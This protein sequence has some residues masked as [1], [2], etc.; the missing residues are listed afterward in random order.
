MLSD[1][2]IGTSSAPTYLPAHFFKT[3]DSGGNEREF[4]LVDGGVAAN[5][6]VREPNLAPDSFYLLNYELMILHLNSYSDMCGNDFAITYWNPGIAGYEANRDSVP[7]KSRCSGCTTKPRLQEIPS[8]VSRDWNF[9]DREEIRCKNGIKVGDHGL[10]LQR[11]P[12][13]F[14]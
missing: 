14:S 2:C 8:A 3:R 9:K 5:N 13:P 12:L 4:H 7:R 1:V 6:P 10:A 11:W